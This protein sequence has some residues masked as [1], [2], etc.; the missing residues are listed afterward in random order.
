MMPTVPAVVSDG[1][2]RLAG[3]LDPALPI[4]LSFVLH[5]RHGRELRD[6]V[7]EVT[8]P[9]SPRYRQFA[10]FDEL[11]ARYAP[12]DDEADRVIAWA[13]ASGLRLVHRN[14]ANF[15]VVMDG[16]VGSV[17]KAFGVQFGQYVWQ[18]Q[19]F[20]SADREPTVPASIAPLLDDIRGLHGLAISHGI[21]AAPHDVAV[22]SVPPGPYRTEVSAHG[23][24]ERSGGRA[25]P[26]ITSSGLYEPPDIA[27]SFAYDFDALQPLSRCCNPGHAP[28]GSPRET[29][30]AIVVTDTPA[31]SDLAAFAQRYGLAYDFTNVQIDGPA[32]CNQE[33]TL[34]VEWATATANSFASYLDTAH[35]YEYSFPGTQSFPG[36]ALNFE[37]EFYGAIVE[38]LTDDRARVLSMSLAGAES[39]YEDVLGFTPGISDFANLTLSLALTGWSVVAASGDRGAYQDCSTL[40][41]SYPAS[42]PLVLAVGGTNL[43]LAS[44]PLEYIGE[45]AW[46]GNG[47]AAPKQNGGGG[48]GGCS[49]VFFAPFWQA[50]LGACPGGRRALPDVALNAAGKGQVYYYGGSLSLQ[51]GTSIAAPEMAGFLAQENSY[52]L[53]L[54]SALP[55]PTIV[56]TAAIPMYLA[57]Q[58]IPPPH[59]P[60]YDITSGCNQGNV[61]NGYCAGPGYDLATGM[62]SLNVLQLAWAINYEVEPLA[63]APAVG[64]TEATGPYGQPQVNIE[65]SGGTLGPA[66]F[67]AQW[68]A[69]PGDPTSEPTP[70]SGTSFYTGPQTIGT[71]GALPLLP[72]GC[73][74]AYVRAWDNVGHSHL[75]TLGPLCTCNGSHCAEGQ[76]CVAGQCCDADAAC[77]DTCCSSAGSRCVS[78]RLCFGPPF[79]YPP[80]CFTLSQTCC[81]VR[82]AC[83]SFCC[84]ALGEA[85]AHDATTGAETCCA[86][87]QTC[88]SLCCTDPATGCATAGGTHVC[89]PREDICD[90][91]CVSGGCSG[92]QPPPCPNPCG[93]YCCTIGEVCQPGNLGPTCQ[94]A[95]SPSCPAGEVLCKGVCQPENQA[96]DP[97]SADAGGE[98]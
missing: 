68:D 44:P 26:F 47:C 18:G 83:S 57:Y 76:V 69:D 56:G 75:E 73:H 25:R 64:L 88:G 59:V 14:R 86:Q 38:A 55:R 48:G 40:S 98:P 3:A 52:L 60:F 63:V 80:E 89:C 39:G 2:A 49:S 46:S 51:G 70:G 87:A 54:R 8:D 78:D 92:G 11:A 65:V 19:R 7:A 42:D 79:F 93:Q 84:D 23:D 28:G 33:A 9:R 45:F 17:E 12:G 96:C 24:A 74:T 32:C 35:V 90:G 61:G 6:R 82:G 50:P 71:R 95:Q 66:G 58:Q 36:P 10:S 30:I 4:R 91:Q 21:D 62:G 29:S 85:C 41:V 34:D 5:L 1:R 43:V 67:T 27:S 31:I 72:D 20:F 13:T 81:S 97:P 37:N 94:G 22:P 77:G 15:V 16:T 53:T